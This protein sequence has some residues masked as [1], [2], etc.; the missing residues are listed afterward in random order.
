MDERRA[1]IHDDL[2]DVIEGEMLFSPVDRAPY[3]VDASLYEIDPLGV[4]LPKHKADLVSLLK[5]AGDQGIPLHPRGAGTSMAG[6]TLGSGLVVD[7]SK[8][9][10]RIVEVRGDRVVVQPGVVLNVLN[11][12]LAPIGRRIGP[13]PSGPESRTIGGMIGAD[14]AGARSLRF[15]SMAGAVESLEVLFSNGESSRLGR[16]D[17]PTGDPGDSSNFKTTLLRKLGTLYRHQG[18]AFA[19]A[20][21]KSP[22]NRAGYAFDKAADS[23]GIDLARLLVG[24]EGTLA[25]VTEATLR[26]VPIP[27][28]QGVVVLPFASLADAAAVVSDILTY[29]PSACELFDWRSLSLA[30]DAVPAYRAWLPETAEAA[31]IVQFDGDDPEDIRDRVSRLVRRVERLVGLVAEPHHATKKLDCEPILNLRRV[32]KPLLMR[33]KGRMRPLA[34]IED[35]AVPPAALP[36]FLLR[37]Q[38]ILKRHDVSW[39]LYAHAGHGQI[40]ARP[41]LDLGDPRDV[42]KL[43]PIA[44]EV[45]EAAW[46]HGGTISGE[47]GCGL[48]RTQFL[49]GQYGDAVHVFREIKDAFDPQYLLNPGKVVGDDTHLMLASLR[50]MPPRAESNVV[51]AIVSDSPLPSLPMLESNLRW[52]GSSPWEEAAAC[53]GCGSCRTQDANMRMCPSFRALRMEMASP[54]AQANLLRQIA[55]GATDPRLWGGEEVKQHADL[56]IHCNLCVQECPSAVDVSSLMMEAKAAY[57]QNH[58]LPPV[59]WM[60]SRL[61]KWS[62][63]AS[64]FPILSNA[65]LASRSSRWLI[66][67]MFGLSRLRRIPKAHRTPFTARAER[68]GLSKAKPHAP[69]PRVVYFVDI[70]ANYFDQELAEAVVAVLRQSGVN[71]FVPRKQRGSGMASL[72]AGDLDHAREIA[73]TNLRVLSNA[74]RDGYTVV[75]SEPTAALMLQKYYLKLTND[76][77]AELVANNTMDIGHYLLGLHQRGQMPIPQQPFHARLGYHQ[78]CHLRGLNIGMP[79]VELMRMIPEL[80]VQVIDRGCSGMAGTY[81]LA[82][83][84]FRTSLRA[85]RG[86]IGRLRED[87]L[88]FGATECGACRIQMEQGVAKRT[89]H[90]IKVLSLA[91]GMNPSL[92][93]KLK[94]PKNKHTLS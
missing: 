41:F 73:S 91:Y 65:L 46:E 38:N 77:D 15:G 83:K 19:K 86:L 23:T 30:R 50:K 68:L 52:N 87:D 49:R 9:F 29:G 66:E 53:N 55:S 20:Q 78:P 37:L 14:A 40:H 93:A 45:Y 16:E 56:C 26:T 61:E 22:R 21:P 13:D 35:V 90:P 2:R 79:G 75:C 12:Q 7:F 36:S 3:A 69:G 70:F 5:Y 94:A 62:S 81:G 27:T 17:W 42:A 76:L 67:R 4:I 31:L 72:V 48:A 6:E 11:A 57:V 32:I 58:G 51:D 84:N 89:L 44:S 80:D 92:Q 85:G 34:F 33:I 25:F 1:R 18:E 10:R 60:L 54:R 47:H 59:D 24:S 28:A 82:R 71:V 74:I 64:R 63:I 39:T 43:E 8:H 88:E